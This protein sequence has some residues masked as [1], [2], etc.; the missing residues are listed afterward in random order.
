MLF[1]WGTGDIWNGPMENF[2]QMMIFKMFLEKSENLKKYSSQFTPNFPSIKIL[3][4]TRKLTHTNTT[5]KNPFRLIQFSSLQ[6]QH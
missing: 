4:P 3:N 6:R 1:R 5:T 2:G